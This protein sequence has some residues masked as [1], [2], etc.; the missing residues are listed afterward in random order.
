MP[1]FFRLLGL[2][3]LGLL[4]LGMV[5]GLQGLFRS[6]LVISVMFLCIFIL[7]QT[8]FMGLL[9]PNEVYCIF[10]TVILTS[11]LS[12]GKLVRKLGNSKQYNGVLIC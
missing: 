9:L 3:Q 6:S 7:A 4:L 1:D 10:A 2:L 11:L 8:F 5:V 12:L